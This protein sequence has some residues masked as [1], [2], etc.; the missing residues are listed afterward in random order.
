MTPLRAPRAL[1]VQH[2]DPSHQLAQGD[3]EAIGEFEEVQVRRIGLPTNDR[4]NLIEAQTSAVVS[5]GLL[6][7]IR[8]LRDQH[9]DS[10]R[11]RRV[12]FTAWFALPQ[13]WHG[14]QPYLSRLRGVSKYI[15]YHRCRRLST[16]QF[17][18]T[19]STEQSQL[20]SLGRSIRALREEKGLDLKQL[21]D[22]AGIHH[23]RLTKLEEGRLDIDY[24]SL[25]KLAAALDVGTA[26]IV[27]RAKRFEDEEAAH[28]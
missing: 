9:F 16:A 19:S 24:E 5:D 28:E 20:L 7:H 22:K 10:L 26:T 3:M 15:G 1:L 12:I 4:V 17:A 23:R 6:A 8:L 18:M 27:D 25:V 14:R 2:I 13:R 11:E 21:A